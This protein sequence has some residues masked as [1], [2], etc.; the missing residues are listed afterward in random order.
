MRSE[1]SLLRDF[2]VERC[3]WLLT[4]VA[5]ISGICAPVFAVVLL[6]LITISTN[7]F[8]YHR[9]SMNPV[10]P[11]G[12][13]L[14]HWMVLVPV[15]GGLIVGLMARFGSDKIRGHGIPEAIEEILI[16][17][18]RVNPKIAIPKPVSAAI[19]IGSGGPFGAEGPI[20]MTGGAVGSLIGQWLHVTDAER[21][22]LLV[23]GAAAGMSAMFDTPVAAV[24]LAVELLLFEWRPRSLAPV[25]IAST[26]AALLRVPWLDAGPLFQMPLL[27]DTP[28]ISFVI[29]AQILG[30]FLG[31]VSAGMSRL[32]YA[33]ED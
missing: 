9:L 20:I 25:A 31:V 27:A 7:I 15:A 33:L 19:A 21:T 5:I 22:A 14:G 4:I 26:T 24:L 13:L 12:S 2:T 17:R 6:R 10:S 28:R 23:A 30:A 29:D 8:H 32:M 18:A 11:A 16:H 3:V 1:P